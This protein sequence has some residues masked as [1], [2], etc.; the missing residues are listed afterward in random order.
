M[1]DVFIPG[2]GHVIPY[3]L[4]GEGMLHQQLAC[5]DYSLDAFGAQL[6]FGQNQK[7]PQLLHQLLFSSCRGSSP[8]LDYAFTLFFQQRAVF[9][10]NSL[11]MN[12][13]LHSCQNP[14]T[15][16][17]SIAVRQLMCKL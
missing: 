6:V 15:E 11:T 7:H 13:G 2:I 4:H 16:K 14:A 9:Q 8:Y 1:D 17:F 5:R 10:L 12:M 3:L